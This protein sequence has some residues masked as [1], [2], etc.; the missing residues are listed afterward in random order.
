MF[1][2]LQIAFLFYSDVSLKAL[3]LSYSPEGFDF[4]KG[5]SQ[6]PR[7]KGSL[8]QVLLDTSF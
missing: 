5:L 6:S 1:C 3:V 4:N 8:C 7:G 2:H